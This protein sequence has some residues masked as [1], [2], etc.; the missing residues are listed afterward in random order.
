M[1][2]NVEQIHFS[3]TARR[4]SQVLPRT[5][6]LPQ[7]S[8]VLFFSDPSCTMTR[9]KEEDRKTRVVSRCGLGGWGTRYNRRQDILLCAWP[10]DA[11]GLLEIWPLLVC[12]FHERRTQESECLQK[13]ENCTGYVSHRGLIF[14]FCSV[15][16]IHPLIHLLSSLF[17]RYNGNLKMYFNRPL[18]MLGLIPFYSKSQTSCL[19]V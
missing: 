2:L 15:Y 7:A 3:R 19:N 6:I 1:V 4:Q 12:E 10:D 11:L 8:L 14:R 17:V 13:G 18:V 9:I 16:L 5:V